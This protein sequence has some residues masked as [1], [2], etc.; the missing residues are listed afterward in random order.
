MFD[1][2]IPVDRSGIGNMKE[3]FAAE[4]PLGDRAV[5][6][7]GAEMD[8]AT[9]PVI[10]NALSDFAKRGI[11]GFTIPDLRYQQ[12]IQAWMK[13]VRNLKVEIDEIVPTL[14]TIFAMNTAIR[15]F[16]SEDDGVIV[17]HPSYYRYDA[18]IQSNMRRVVSNPMLEKNGSY[19][20]DFDSLEQCMADKRNKLLI[21][22]NP[23][24][25]TGK[26]FTKEALK[27]IRDL[28]RK[29]GVIVFSDEIFAE[30]TFSNH[31]AVS[32]ASIDPDNSIIST[33]LGKVFNFTGVNHANLIIKNAALREIY[34]KQRAK[35]HFG[36]ID[37]FFYQAV[38]AGYSAEGFAWVEAL[39]KYIWENYC[40]LKEG[41]TAV[42]PKVRL[43]PLEGGFVAW[44][45]LRPLGY[46]DA[47][48]KEFLEMK[49]GIIG[50]MGE[51][52]GAGG[53][54]FLR[55]NIATPRNSIITFVKKLTDACKSD[56]R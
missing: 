50:D 55:I 14:G 51:E 18:G 47:E 37:P 41:L 39:K 40:E 33:S 16:T 26:V 52:Y 1:F 53:E 46:S 31:S 30:I 11:Y 12:T 32:Y 27:Q 6:L 19:S 36:S 8:F 25:P 56:K 44:L 10:R 20:I 24:N 13:E 35:D 21:L 34:I 54:G 15:A 22:C 49:A 9:A 28:A 38:I 7:S 45:D 2:D 48:L 43:C 5:V 3:S 17:Q 29:Y 4:S 42:Q 23:H